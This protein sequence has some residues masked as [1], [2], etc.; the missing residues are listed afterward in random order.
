MNAKEIIAIVTSRIGRKREGWAFCDAAPREMTPE[1]SA[2]FDE[3]FDDRPEDPAE[4][5]R[6][7]DLIGVA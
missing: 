4:R 3:Y 6:L 2:A 7:R 5:A 1:Q